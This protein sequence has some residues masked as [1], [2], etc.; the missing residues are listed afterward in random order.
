[1]GIDVSED[2]SKMVTSVAIYSD[3]GKLIRTVT[4]DASNDFQLQ[5]Q[6]VLKQK[7]GEDGKKEAEALLED[8]GLQ[9]TISVDCLG[10]MHLITGNA[11]ILKENTS[12]ASG[13]F[14]IDSDT[15]TWK[16]KQYFCKLKLNF[17]NLMNETTGGSEVK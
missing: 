16:N 13:L 10:D 14:W 8:N 2:I 3:D 15:H 4:G 11:V 1:M 5:L 7:K 9:Q 6:R 17:R 12:G